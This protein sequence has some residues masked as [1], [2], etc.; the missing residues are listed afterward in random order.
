MESVIYNQEGKE[1][2]KIKL[3]EGVFGATWNADL[4]HQVTTSMLSSVRK[5]YGHTKTRGEVAGGGKKP[6]RQKGT[7][8]ARH[9]SIRSPIWVGGGIAHG[10]RNE[11]NFLRK[12]SKKTKDR[13]LSVILS[14]K[15]SDGE[16]FFLDKLTLSA[17]KTKEAKKVIDALALVKGFGKISAKRQNAALIVLPK[18]NI[19]IERAFNNFSNLEV[20]EVRNLNPISVLNYSLA[21]FTEPKETIAFLESRFAA[22]NK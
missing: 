20:V 5:P 13:A 12:V 15:N 21:V 1:T 8:R 10:P 16:V 18:K 6:W 19:E 9:G 17:V 4:V 11:K 22:K 7:G 3:P 2:G 14:K